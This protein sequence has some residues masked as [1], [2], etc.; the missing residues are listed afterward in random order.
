MLLGDILKTF[1]DESV[2]TEYL[3][4]LGNIPLLRRLQDLAQREGETLGE[5]ASGAVQ[6]YASQASE[7]EWLTLIGL[8]SRADDPA[9]ICLQRAL[10]QAAAT[11]VHAGH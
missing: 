8:I 2:A 7:E 4:S 10:E 6:R 1:S 3:L 9:R 11:A 5:F